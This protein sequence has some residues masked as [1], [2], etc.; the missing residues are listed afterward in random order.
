VTQTG[1]FAETVRPGLFGAVV[2]AASV[3][4]AQAEG[5]IA[6]SGN[7]TL[8]T[9]YIFRGITNS[10]E[11]PAVQPALELYYKEIFYAGVWGTNVDFG[12]GANGQDLAN[13]EIDYFAAITP[14]LGKWSFELAAYYYSYPGA[15]D[16]D[17]EFDY[18]E[19]WTG[20]SRTFLNEKLT[21]KLM[22]YWS[23]DNF[24][25]TGNNDVLE[26][27]YQWAFQEV[28]YFKPKL[29]GL[30]GHQWGDKSAGGFDYTYWN[31]GFALGF[32]KKPQLELEIRYWDTGGFNGFTCPPSGVNACGERVVASLKATFGAAED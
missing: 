27:Q 11:K 3:A 8:T 9:D 10:A 5:D 4:P 2:L 1:F 18:L 21:L 25:E 14:T 32:N 7:A 26:L 16:P 28:W 20:I 31:V 29:V 22:N 12:S 15:F 13:I 19:I 24:G 17:G 30:V 6:I 23:P